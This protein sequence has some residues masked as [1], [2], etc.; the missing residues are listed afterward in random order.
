MH[1]FPWEGEVDKKDIL[2]K[3]VVGFVQLKRWF[4]GGWFGLGEGGELKAWWRGR[5]RKRDIFIGCHFGVRK[6]SGARETPR[7]PQRIT[8]TNFPS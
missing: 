6:K 7:N 5:L 4:R 8:P 3:L 1:G 2:G